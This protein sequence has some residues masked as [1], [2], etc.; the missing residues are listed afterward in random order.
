[1]SSDNNTHKDSIMDIDNSST[2]SRAVV[3][4]NGLSKC[5]WSYKRPIQRLWAALFPEKQSG[6][7]FWALSDVS[8]SVMPGET[9]GLVGKN[10]AGKS[11]LLQLITGILQ[12][13]KGSYKTSGRV[14]ALLELG[15]G[16]NPE[17][18]GLE[19]ARLNASLMGLTQQEF[20][21]ALPDIIEFS[22]LGDYIERP[23]KTYSSGMFVRLA[24]AVAIN[25]RPDVLIID[26]ALAVGDIRFQSKCFRRLDAL[27]AKGVSIL[28]VTH[29]TESIIKYCDR[30]VLIDEGKL[31]QIGEPKDVVQRYM[32][33]MFDSDVNRI[34]RAMDASAQH[35]SDLDPNIDYCPQQ[36]GYNANEER[37]GD[38]RAKIFHYEL[39]V[40]NKLNCRA[41]SGQRLCLRYKVAFFEA[42]E[43]VIFGMTIKLAS[44][45]TVYATNTRLQESDVG[46]LDDLSGY[47][48][49]EQV[50]I[51]F[52]FEANLLPS[53]YFISLG[54]AQDH[55]D[56]DNIAIDRRYDMVHLQIDSIGPAKAFGIA[57]LNATIECANESAKTTIN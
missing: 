18:T 11:T 21:E 49:G 1:M 48:Q 33:M 10:G 5:Y 41:Y 29:S 40:D 26:E 51:S 32:E 57:E 36:L 44:G 43:G 38:L 2:S 30:A 14:S 35:D 46:G 13:T 28:F 23:V 3:E 54:V 17:F 25:M 19:N 53:D 24:F 22:G 20:T 37:W 50:Q 52:T 45:E 6:K 8:F 15:A 31:V 34:D 55:T 47:Q 39:L 12:P 9:V 16:F 7:A 56:K 27:K 4:L 42:L